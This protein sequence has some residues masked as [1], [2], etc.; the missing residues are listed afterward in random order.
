[1]KRLLISWIVTPKRARKLIAKVL[2]WLILRCVLKGTWDVVS[3][4]PVWLRK[5]ADFIERWNETELT[6]ERDRLIAD[7]VSDAVTDE[8]VDKLIDRI[9][10]MKMEQAGEAVVLND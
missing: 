8:A 9:S 3:A 2:S 1:M 7:L 5:L 10:A 6:E 4:L